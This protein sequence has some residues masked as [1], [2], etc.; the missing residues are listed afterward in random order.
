MLAQS[1]FDILAET[2]DADFTQGEIG[3]LQRKRVWKL[4]NKVLNLY[5]RPLK[6]LEINCGTGED[7]LQLASMGHTVIAT[8][9]SEIM[10]E[11]AQQKLYASGVNSKYIYFM[12]CSF[13]EL[14]QNFKNEKFDLVFSNFGG[15]NCITE[16]EIEK[17]SDTL[18]SVTNSNGY[19]FL[20]IM[21]SCCLWEILFYLLKGKSKTAFR[22]RKKSVLF[23]VNDS[24]MPVYYYS[25]RHI[26]KLFQ[27]NFKPVQTYPVGLL[28]PP[29]YLEKQFANRKHWL[30]RLNRLEENFGSSLFSS[31][32][33][34]F[35]IVMKRN[36]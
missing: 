23:N 15:L 29:S 12:Q 20:N 4:L 16:N 34:H 18:S 25:P 17:L 24:S 31:F 8:D 7:A 27:H 32:A 2:Y 13:D 9:A 6:I 1:P 33:D 22:R 5:D 10:I 14:E 36:I 3:K 19:L 21:S 11:K 26:K 30:S 28:I 35:C